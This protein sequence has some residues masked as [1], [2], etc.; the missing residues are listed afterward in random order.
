ME[1]KLRKGRR[2]SSFLHISQHIGS[3]GIFCARH[4]LHLAL[5]PYWAGSYYLNIQLEITGQNL[6]RPVIKAVNVGESA[7]FH[8][9]LNM[10]AVEE[11]SLYARYAL[12]LA[13]KLSPLR[14]AASGRMPKC[15]PKD[16]FGSSFCTFRNSRLNFLKNLS[17]AVSSHR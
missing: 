2:I 11:F 10:L 14:W 8:I 15:I 13:L 5:K 16:E 4:A 1:G 7:A 12:H 9:F 3:W 6:W 17:P